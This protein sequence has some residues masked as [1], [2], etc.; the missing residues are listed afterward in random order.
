MGGETLCLELVILQ[1]RD[2]D[3]GKNIKKDR[4]PRNVDMEEIGR[5]N[6]KY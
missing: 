3:L 5:E 6:T 1:G 4:C 2:M